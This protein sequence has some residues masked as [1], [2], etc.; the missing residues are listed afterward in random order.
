MEE[1][2]FL[3]LKNVKEE[4]PPTLAKKTAKL[5]ALQKARLISLDHLNSL[6]KI[7]ADLKATEEEKEIDSIKN[8]LANITTR[9]QHAYRYFLKLEERR[10]EKLEHDRDALQFLSMHV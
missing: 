8:K 2:F 1:Y 4:I 9:L 10:I 5:D 7:I 3:K 6:I